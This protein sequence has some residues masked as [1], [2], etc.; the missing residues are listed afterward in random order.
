MRT[1][2]TF[3]FLIL[4]HTLYLF[5]ETQDD[6]EIIFTRIYDDAVWGKNSEGV[7]YSG[8]GSL[9]Q[10]VTF[11]M[12]FVQSFLKTH[13]IK[14][15]VDAGC[16]DWEFSR[17]MNWDGVEYTGYDVV[18]SVIRKNQERY[19]SENIH[20]IHSNF[21]TEDLPVTDLILCKHVLQHLT[22]A[23]IALFIKQLPKFKYCLITNQVE[24]TT[25]TGD[26]ADIPIGHCHKVDLT[27]SPFYMKGAGVY[28][29]QADGGIHQILLI[30]GRN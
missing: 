30:D 22:N 25:L 28:F 18:E 6:H 15:V 1:I 5:S 14:T 9:V 21:L 23:D 3:F 11:Y 17:F 2:F 29:Y 10:N 8:G 20:F 26:N 12:D 16:G 13:N 4:V 24:N 7:G 27:K 19:G